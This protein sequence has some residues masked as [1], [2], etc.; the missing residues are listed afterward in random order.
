MN[1]YFIGNLD[2]YLVQDFGKMDM[3][4]REYKK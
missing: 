1:S 2:M 4:L 3:Q